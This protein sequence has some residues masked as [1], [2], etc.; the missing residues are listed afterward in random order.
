[1]TL[2]FDLSRVDTVSFGIGRD[3]GDA[4][5]FVLVP[6]D[7]RVQAALTDMAADTWEVMRGITDTPPLY[8]PSEKHGSIEYVHIPVSSDLAIR[9]KQLHEAVNVPVDSGALSDLGS[10]FC[11]FAMMTDEGG[12]RLTALRRAAH[13]K[14]IVK[15]RLI[16]VVTDALTLV[17]DRVFK[18]D[19]DFD[20]LIDGQTVHILRPAGFE[21]AGKLQEEILKAAP[22][23]AAALQLDLPYVDFESIHNYAGKHP[24]AARYL[25][26]IRGQKTKNI[27]QEAL[28]DL[29]VATGVGVQIDGDRLIIDGGQELAFLEVLDRRR[30]QVNLVSDTPERFRASSRNKLDA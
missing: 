12:R 5:A 13:F 4:Q 19:N 21:F 18:L 16:R 9:M 8:E 17:E 27:S 25:A 10:L 15:S 2:D 7:S 3:E 24:R 29:C 20:L 11:Y 14:G 23:N 6:T 26:S 22:G 28:V 30:Y 1:M